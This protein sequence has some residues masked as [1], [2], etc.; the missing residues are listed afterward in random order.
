MLH[1][2]RYYLAVRQRAYQARIT[3]EYKNILRWRQ[4]NVRSFTSLKKNT[5]KYKSSNETFFYLD[6]TITKQK[7][8]MKRKF[9]K[10]MPN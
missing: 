2:W 10:I 6:G 5:L 9:Y 4:E 3:S 7:D 8:K 1:G